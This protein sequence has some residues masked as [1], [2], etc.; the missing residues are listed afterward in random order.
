MMIE[1]GNSY[2]LLYE[3]NRSFECINWETSIIVALLFSANE[4]LKVLM[5]H[6]L[7]FFYFLTPWVSPHTL[8]FST[9]CHSFLNS[10]LPYTYLYNIMEIWPESDLLS[11]S[12][13]PKLFKIHRVDI[14]LMVGFS[15]Q[16][17]KVYT[18]IVYM[19][20]TGK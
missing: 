18:I 6:I 3:K 1:L 16:F 2:F 4:L 11:T 15:Q 5:C 20:Y 7:L 9:S 10:K 12:I 14:G 19:L 17:Q 8:S 13:G